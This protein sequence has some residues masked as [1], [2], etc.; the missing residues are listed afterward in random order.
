MGFTTIDNV[1]LFL[2]KE[3]LTPLEQ[4]QVGLLLS[5]VDGIIENYCGR[6]KQMLARDYTARKY[7]GN[8]T[9]DLNLRIWPVN[10]VTA[11]TLDGVNITAD[12]EFDKET[13][14]LTYT[15]NIFTDKGKVLVTFNGGYPD[16]E[17]P[18]DLMYAA[19]YLAFNDAKRIAN[20][21]LGL[22]EGKFEQADFKLATTDLPPLV[23]RLLE[24]HRLLSIY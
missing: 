18:N 16:D 2:N 12:V 1:K 8:G 14:V 11:V 9:A 13:G 5:A 3:T 17:I 19:T 23:T 21:T 4:F 24:R 22:S 15:D 10:T 6:E 7:T 20:G